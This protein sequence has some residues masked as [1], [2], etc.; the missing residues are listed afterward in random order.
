MTLTLIFA[1]TIGAVA[2]TERSAE[3]LLFAIAALL[4]NAALFLIFVADFER[5]ILLSGMLA[6]A[7]AGASILK[8]NH[9]ALKLTVSDLP[10]VFAGTVP[11]FVS[12]YPRA[13]FGVLAGS[14]LLVLASTAVLLYA[15]GSPI[16][17]EF[18]VVL[19]GLALISFE[20][21]P[22]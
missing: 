3:H 8:F 10:L 12:Q 18:R 20:R 1:A 19:F 15:A 9:S 4:F 7:I 2:W 5:A 17:L 21:P 22:G 6:V 13:M 11:F 14:V 16:S